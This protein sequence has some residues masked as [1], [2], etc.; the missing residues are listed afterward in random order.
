MLSFVDDVLNIQSCGRK[1]VKMNEYTVEE[2]NKRKL[3]LAPD[4]C[5]RMHVGKDK[6]CL[7]LHI[8]EWELVKENN[9]DN[10]SLLIDHHKGKEKIKFTKSQEYLGSIVSSDGSNNKTLDARVQRVQGVINDI[11][12]H[13]KISILWSFLC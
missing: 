8:D 7:D 2:L 11:F 4:K 10:S 5:K 6:L 13:F 12:K 1:V 3:Q 9:D